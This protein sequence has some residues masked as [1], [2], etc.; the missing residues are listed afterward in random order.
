MKIKMQTIKNGYLIALS[1]LTI[2]SFA[3]LVTASSVLF[4]RHKADITS[5]HRMTMN[6]QSEKIVKNLESPVNITVYQSENLGS[7]YP[8][9]GLQSQFL[10]RL[11]E[12]YQT[13]S[14]GKITINVKNPEPFS[15]AEEEAQAAGIRAFPDNTG[16]E[17][18]YFGAIFTSEKGTA[19]T[20]PYFSVQRQNYTEYD[21]S[22]ILGKF[23]KF[24]KK[25]IGI[26]DFG[27]DILKGQFI[28]KLENDYNVETINPQDINIPK[29]ISV[30]L[31]NNPQQV[32]NSFIYAIDQYIMRGGK[33]IL[34]VDPYSEQ[35][36]AKHPTSA[37]QKNKLLPL[38]NKLGFQFNQDEVIGDKRLSLKE[39]QS[40]RRNNNFVLWFDVP[41]DKNSEN[42]FT[43]GFLNF[44]FRSPGAIFAGNKENASYQPVFATSADGGKVA[45]DFAKFA[46]RESVNNSFKSDGNKYVLGYFATGWFESLFERSVIAGTEQEYK[47]PPFL[48]GSIE[49]AS[50]LVVADSDFIEDDTWNLAKYKENSTVYDQI[51]GANNADFLLRAIDIMSGNPDIAGLYPNYLINTDKSIGEQIYNHVF[52]NYAASYLEKENEIAALQNNFEAFKASLR[53]NEVGMSIVKIQEI[54]NYHRKLQKLQEDLKFVEY[55]IKTA[56]ERKVAEIIVMN[57]LLFPMLLIMLWAVGIKFYKHRQKQKISRLINE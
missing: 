56:N 50:I 34:L 11:L 12:K 1:V 40:I 27:A 41:Q 45:A 55:R 42:V 22:R 39:R 31:V 24:Q 2:I 13:L 53:S 7:E 33:L 46:D 35:T 54:E 44:S 9:L 32:P 4:G 15:V 47:L 18:L 6:P 5:L 29:R 26:A 38:L 17:N 25:T 23:G 51:P 30:L 43:D 16:A 28:K 14:D 8:E 36:V 20:I 21:I 49:P 3:M 57:A 52:Q 19:F 48:I 37:V 10:F